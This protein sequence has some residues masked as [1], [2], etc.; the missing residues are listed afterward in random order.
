MDNTNTNELTFGERLKQLREAKRY[1]R[2]A[3]AKE[4]GIPEKSLEKFEYGSATPTI[5]RLYKLAEV[6]DVTTQ[7]LLDGDTPDEEDEIELDE[8]DDLDEGLIE[9]K[10]DHID[11]LRE[12]G[13]HISWRSAPKLIAEI[14]SDIATYDLDILL[15]LAENRGLFVI[16]SDEIATLTKA[17]GKTK[18]E[19]FAEIV[20]RI[21]DTLYFGVDLYAIRKKDLITLADDLEL[22]GD[23]EG[24]LSTSWS[25][26]AAIVTA[27]RP[28]CRAEA[29]K[30]KAPDFEND[31]TFKAREVV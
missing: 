2:S 15:D 26:I 23:V 12:G 3:L 13:F 18:T 30:S 19:M 21:L 8:I 7:H 28:Y 11:V 31:E 4:T 22:K 27:L 24:F 5:D 25:S 10:C 20:E 6:L 16:T 17:T 1:S 29:L 9:M 14:M